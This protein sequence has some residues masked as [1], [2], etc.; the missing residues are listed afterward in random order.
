[1][2]EIDEMTFKEIIDAF[3]A[4]LNDYAA[5]GFANNEIYANAIEAIA[6]ADKL[7]PTIHAGLNL[8]DFWKHLGRAD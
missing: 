1:M 8:E 6:K 4:L 2:S 3:R 5:I 7:V